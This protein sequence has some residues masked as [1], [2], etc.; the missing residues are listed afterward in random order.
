MEP[1]SFYVYSVSKSGAVPPLSNRTYGGNLEFRLQP[2]FS[3]T[4]DA[5]GALTVAGNLTVTS[6][7]I[8]LYL[9]NTVSLRGNLQVDAGA[10]L[11][12]NPFASAPQNVV[13]SGTTTQTISGAGTLTFG[14]KSNLQINN[15]AGVTLARP[16]S[17]SRLELTNGVLSTDAASL[18][19]LP[20]GAMLAGGSASSFI[21][22]P[23]TRVTAGPGA[24]L[25]PIG[26]GSAY[27][28]LTL[29]IAQ[30]GVGSTFR[31][32]QVEGA[33]GQSFADPDPNGV[34][35]RVSFKRFFRLVASSPLAENFLG[36]VMLSYGA[37]D[38]VNRPDD[39]G[40]VV[41]G[42]NAG[43]APWTNRGRSATGPGTI[44][45]AD[46]TN[47]AFGEESA[48]ALG[49]TNENLAGAP[50]INPLPVELISF[51]AER[52]PAGGVQLRWSTATEQNSARFEVQRSP[53]G[54]AF[55]TVATVAA[56]GSSARRSSYASLDRNAPAGRL[57][58]R[59]RQ[60][61]ADGTAHFS[62][63]LSVTPGAL[64]LSLFPNPA[65]TTVSFQNLTG[66]AL[67]YRVLNQLGQVVQA[68]QAPA[69]AVRVE[70]ADL[71]VG[72]YL[73]ELQTAAGRVGH[74]LV[75]E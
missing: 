64:A 5:N 33:A 21:S 56:Q 9:D 28:P 20:A 19:T 17:L 62:P 36:T 46:L 29:T 57:Y 71:A 32:E 52:Q 43:T 40:L 34:L 61:D 42:R 18:L 24:V 60:V 35:K 44:T 50:A 58:Y 4:T 47:A 59:L 67:P 69:G 37:D 8:G 14:A 74:R 12:L 1:G 68:G 41:A 75:K 23:L 13:L 39:A 26:K 11:I 49:A 65:R 51:A 53:D 22:G 10:T 66:A 54:V 72:T 55:C 3:A 73:L 15:P 31:A 25:F 30:Q 16:L 63:T 48:F 6:G 70:V 27:R 38:G 45:S 2:G 7:T